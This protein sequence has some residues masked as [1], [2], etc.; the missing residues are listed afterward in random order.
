MGSC[1]ARW[2]Q[3][4]IVEFQSQIKNAK[5]LRHPSCFSAIDSQMKKVFA[6]LLVFAI[7]GAL[8]SSTVLAG[9]SATKDSSLAG[10]RNGQWVSEQ[11][12]VG[13]APDAAILKALAESGLGLVINLQTAR[14]VGFDEKAVVE[15]LG[16]TYLHLP[17]S[18]LG[19]LTEDLLKTL[20]SRLPPE[21]QK[22][23]LVHCASGN[24]VGAAFALMAQ[25]FDGAT[26][27]EAIAVGRQHG[28]TQLESKVAVRLRE[29]AK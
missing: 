11:V 16:M 27:F 13:G 24:R 12:A 28:L 10:L 18:S 15:G 19:D 7:S 29:R 2:D 21:G 23:V 9:K 26:V 25:R 20:Y 4:T 3:S 1:C 14:E 17:V 8:F 5:K 6:I 22:K